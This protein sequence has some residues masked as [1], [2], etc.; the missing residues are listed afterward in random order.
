MR[1]SSLNISGSLTG[2]TSSGASKSALKTICSPVWATTSLSFRYVAFSRCST[3]SS[4]PIVLCRRLWIAEKTTICCSMRAM[5]VPTGTLALSL[6]S[7]SVVLTTSLPLSTRNCINSSSTWLVGLTGVGMKV[8]RMSSCMI[9][10]SISFVWP[11]STRTDWPPTGPDLRCTPPGKLL[12]RAESSS[13]RSAP[14]AAAAIPP[15]TWG[16]PIG[17]AP[18]QGRN[19]HSMMWT[20]SSM[21]SSSSSQL[22]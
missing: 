14:V 4:L 22:R 7:S 13:A 3:L 17:M 9:P 11:A 12:M 19:G 21:F 1:C 6:A 16:A 18:R 20:S 5:I 8:L 2:I 15:K 10:P